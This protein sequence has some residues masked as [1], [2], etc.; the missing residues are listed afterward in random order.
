MAGQLEKPDAPSPKEENDN[1]VGEGWLVNINQWSE[2]NS[3]EHCEQ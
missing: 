2:I 3:K 1:N